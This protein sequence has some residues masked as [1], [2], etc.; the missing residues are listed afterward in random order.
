MVLEARG[1]DVTPAT[2]DRLRAA[3][4]TAS[5]DILMVIYRDEIG[6]VG[7][8][9]RWF[10]RACADRR[11]DPVAAWRELVARYF[12]G[13][14]KPPFND[15]ARAEAGFLKAMYRPTT[16]TRRKRS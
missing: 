4:D 3:G 16:A 6:H 1:L 9:S 13:R 8:G 12:G 5:A 2:V 7:A 11:L 15:A 10:K 14:L